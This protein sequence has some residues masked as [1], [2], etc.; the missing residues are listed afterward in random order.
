MAVDI[1]MAIKDQNGQWLE[2]ES[3]TRFVTSVADDL[4]SDL[5]EAS[6]F[7]V[8]DFDLGIAIEDRDEQ[9]EEAEEEKQFLGQILDILKQKSASS[10]LLPGENMDRKAKELASRVRKQAKRRRFDK[11]LSGE[12]NPARPTIPSSGYPLDFQAFGFSRQ[13]DKAS[14][15]LFDACCN[16]HTLQQAVVLKRKAAGLDQPLTYFRID[17]TDI[18]II[19]LD[20]DVEETVK[21]KVKFLCRS[22]WIRY[23]PQLD[24][25]DLGPVEQVLW[26]QRQTLVSQ[27][28]G[29]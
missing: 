18:L 27:E 12:D 25:G 2:A 21:E 23:R 16:S 15:E 28:D 11:W 19:G 14:V 26:E 20:W 8:D 13:I 4:S 3:Q 5:S 1:I 6:L 10:M 22:A 17:F 29:T 24:S 7:E 9:Q